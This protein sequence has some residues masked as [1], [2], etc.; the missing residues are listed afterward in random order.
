[1]V[2]GSTLIH[3]Q[4]LVAILQTVHPHALVEPQLVRAV[5]M[6]HLLAMARGFQFGFDDA[7]F[8]FRSVP[9]PA[10]YGHCGEVRGFGLSDFPASRHTAFSTC[11]PSCG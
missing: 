10:A 7:L 9:P 2:V 11:I 8:P 1:M 4:L 6:L 3:S 5:L